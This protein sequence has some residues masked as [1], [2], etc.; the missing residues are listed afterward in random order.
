MI[1]PRW[2]KVILD[3]WSN[4][5]RSMLVILSIAVGVFA[6]GMI[7]GANNLLG[8]DLLTAFYATNPAQAELYTTGFEAD[9]MPVIR[10]VD[11]V[12]EAQAITS[13]TMQYQSDPETWSDL[14]IYV[15]PDYRDIRLRQIVPVAGDWPPPH[16]AALVELGSLN[17]MDKSIGDVLRVET[18]NG[19]IHELQIAGTIKDLNQPAVEMSGSP[20]VFVTVDTMELLGNGRF[21]TDILI[22]IEGDDN[23]ESAVKTVMERVSHKFERTGGL[24][25]FSVINPPG[26]HPA[27][28]V[29]DP[30]LLIL[31][32]LG[33]MSLFLSS[34]LV[35]NIINGLLSQHTQQIGVM[36][37]IGARTS[38][39]TV[40]YLVTI[41]IFGLL[42]SAI[43]IPLGGL[44]AFALASF[45]ARLLNFDLGSFT[46]P[47]QAIVIQLILALL[48]PLVAAAYPVFRGAGITVR[49]AISEYGLGKGRFGGSWIDRM[50]NWITSTALNISRPVRIAL[51]NTIRRKARLLLT[52]LTLTL[53][54]AIFIS[55][56]SVYTSLLA[57]L[58]D[59]LDYFN[60]D[61]TVA[62]DRE[63]RIEQLQREALRVDGVVDATSWLGGTARIVMENDEESEILSIFGTDAETD[64]I[65]PVVVEGRWLREDDTNGVVLN[66]AVLQTNNLDIKVGDKLVIKIDGKE[67][68]WEVIGIVRSA[69]TGGLAYANAPYFGRLMNA[70]GRAQ[71]VQVRS[72]LSSSEQQT[73]LAQ[74]LET[75]FENIGL[76]VSSTFTMAEIREQIQFIF[77]VI[78][79]M[80]AVMALLIAGVGGLGLMGTMSINVMERTREIG[81]MRAIGA[82]DRAVLRIILVEGIF[83]GLLSWAI[84]YLVSVPIGKIMSDLIGNALLQSPLTYSFSNMGAFTWLFLVLLISAV[85]SYMPAKNASK[86]S[87]W[88]TLAYE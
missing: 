44:A 47:S 69:L 56:I 22:T 28:E 68:E 14:N 82:S 42:A 53:G 59:G 51:R 13:F 10:R 17:Y 46:I 4:K 20:A 30:L 83:V 80:M 19:R 41:I 38:Q 52:L 24:V 61:V 79:S 25:F 48:V 18:E 36:K 73:D 45:M 62:F 65:K 39:I 16:D 70:Q 50:L 86:M 60:F 43:A 40:M 85:A 12:A 66:T 32:L 58:D 55:I 34:F 3:L 76:S 7:V 71:Q 8:E 35:V 74:R 49:E 2:R 15:Y 11:G 33:S 29:L 75:H 31:G 78:V 57:T 26:K 54:G 88:E 77:S 23:S 27:D 87:V 72:V 67:T 1:R 6:I 81:V 21:F 5:T 63:Y 84:A 37:A 64:F 9:L